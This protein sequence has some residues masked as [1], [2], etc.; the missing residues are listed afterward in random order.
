MDLVN[1]YNP[2]TIVRNLWRHRE[3]IKQFTKRE[4]VGRYRGSYL[5]IMWSF[6]T[7]LLMLAVYTFVFSVIFNSRWGTDTSNKTEYALI[8]FCGLTTF[9]LFAECINRAPGLVLSN[10]NYVKKVVF[11]LEILVV[12][13]VGSALVNALISLTILVAGLAI[14]SGVVNWTLI[15]LPLVLLPL[16]LFTLG[17]GWFLASL[18]VYLRDVGQIISVL[19]QA[20]MFLS[21]ILY[22]ITAIPEELRPIY[23]FN[24]LGYVAED[25]RRIM[26]WGQMP[27][28]NWLITGILIG[29][30]VAILGHVWFQKTRKG[31]NDVL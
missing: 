20:L 22:P 12:V 29:S 6:I 10:A 9:N 31:F 24:P 18:G 26:L 16:L 14:L 17:L 4:V 1:T 13:A 30:F 21:P 8:L 5:G 2:Y 23:H 25:M 3:L 15:F 19:T 7:P 11:P 28:W 27:D